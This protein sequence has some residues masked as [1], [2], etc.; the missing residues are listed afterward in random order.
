MKNGLFTIREISDLFGN[1]RGALRFYEE[2]GL[3]HPIRDAHGFRYYSVKDIFQLFYLKRYGAMSLSLDEV[4]EYF[5]R[6]SVHTVG[7]IQEFLKQK[8]EWLNEQICALQEQERVLKNYQ[9]ELKDIGKTEFTIQ[10]YPEYYSLPEEYFTLF[11]KENSSVLRML[12]TAMP[13]TRVHSVLTEEK[14]E[15]N[16]ITGLGIVRQKAE[17]LGIPGLGQMFLLPNS[18][19]ATKIVTCRKS[20]DEQMV[21]EAMRL[22]REVTE[23]GYTLNGKI[24]FSLLL[25]HQEGDELVEY[26]RIYI[27][28]R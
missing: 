1:T 12:I 28:I 26:F 5:L 13:Y 18:L 20:I 22:K 15:I 16:L 8:R 21:K 24:N 6:E 4:F 2:K 23:Q 3:V 19:A 11:V 7:E 10:E 17:A 14:G 9:E 27:P 25:V